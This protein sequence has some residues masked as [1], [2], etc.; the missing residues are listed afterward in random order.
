MYSNTQILDKKLR[1]ELAIA[2]EM[3]ETKV[4]RSIEWVPSSNQ[5]V[6]TLT[7]QGAAPWKVLD[8]LGN[9]GKSLD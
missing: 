2:R 6:D 3:L 7:K 5:I 1:I 8:Y 4:V 9:S